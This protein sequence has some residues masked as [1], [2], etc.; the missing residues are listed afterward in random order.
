V[1]TRR[2]GLRWLFVPTAPMASARGDLDAAIPLLGGDSQNTARSA[3]LPRPSCLRRRLAA[4]R[5]WQDG[6]Q[7]GTDGDDGVEPLNYIPPVRTT[8]AFVARSRLTQWPRVE[9]PG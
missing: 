5:V 6:A 2:V 1:G 8:S 4:A 3:T 9:L 7:D